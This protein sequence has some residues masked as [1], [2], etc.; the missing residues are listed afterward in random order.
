MEEMNMAC[1]PRAFLQIAGRALIVF[2]RGFFRMEEVG[3]RDDEDEGKEDD[4][5][6]NP[7]LSVRHFV[8]S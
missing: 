5:V 7:F 4:Q 1:G 8:L 2:K 3:K 6:E